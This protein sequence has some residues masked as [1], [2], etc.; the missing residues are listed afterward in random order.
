MSPKAPAVMNLSEEDR[1]L[2]YFREMPCFVSVLDRELKL[3]ETNRLFEERFGCRRGSTCWEVCRQRVI[4]CQSCPIEM[5][6]TTG[7]GQ[8]AQETVLTRSGEKIPIMLYTSP[9][10]D[11]DGEVVRVLNISA[12][13]TKVKR[14]QKRLHRS[15][16]KT[17]RFFDESPCYITVQDRELK[18]TASNRR[19]REDF[20]DDDG[21]HCYELYKHREEPCLECPV[22]ETFSDGMP[23][24]SEEV[25]SS[26]DGEQYNV[27]VNTAPIR[28][29]EGE[30][31]EVMEMSTNITA[32]RNL[33]NQLTSLGL[34]IGS[35]SHGIKGLLTAIDGGMYLV[36]S[37]FPKNNQER[38]QEGWA[39]V[40]RNMR[41]IRSMVL[42]LLYYAKDRELD[43]ETLN[44]LEL[45]ADVW[46][47]V[48]YRADELGIEF[49]R[50]FD[51]TAGEFDADRAALRT[52]LINI[53]E[54]A[55]DA[56]RVDRKKDRHH[57]TFSVG[58]GENGAVLFAVEDNGVGMDRETQERMFTLFFSSKGS[59]GTGLGLFVSNKIIREHGGSI[60]VTSKP[61]KGTRL[62]IC[63]PRAPAFL[64]EE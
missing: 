62:E 47:M 54:N 49:E 6:F 5:T 24:S 31:V 29:S 35:V 60:D 19:F 17:Q 34:L 10:L 12:D 51:I 53:L 63:L 25:V 37:G 21:L 2:R 48:S 36:N 42:D 43:A 4:P 1:Y 27:L 57:V 16:Q 11:D 61:D 3:V 38:I 32:I 7:Q 14:L 23:H 59:E 58:P 9:I 40:Q 55:F 13:I 44:S 50:D 18:L 56:C 15:Q 8:E 30:I 28:N 46:N 41:R 26:I 39:I 64:L 22:M 33:E 52:A 45:A 20:G